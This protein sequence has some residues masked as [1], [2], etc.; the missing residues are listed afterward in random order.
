MNEIM[1]S[2]IDDKTPYVFEITALRYRVDEVEAETA[3]LREALEAV[4]WVDDGERW[5]ECP[6]CHKSYGIWEDDEDL[7]H[8]PD[9]L[10]QC[11]LGKA[12]AK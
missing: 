1:A 10:R 6:W 3:L 7:I 11:A 2:E 5:V 4:E 12:E 8:L 9:C